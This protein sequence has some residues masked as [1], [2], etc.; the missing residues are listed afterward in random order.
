MGVW[1]SSGGGYAAVR[2]LL[3]FPDFYKVGVSLCGNHDQARYYAHWGDR[4][5]GPYS[6][7]AYFD[8][9]NHRFADRLQ[10]KLLLV[11]GD[12]DDNVHTSAT[13]RLAGAFA[14]ANRDVDLLIYPNSGHGVDQYPMSCAGAGTFL[15]GTFWGR[16]RL[17]T[18]TW[19]R[20]QSS[21]TKDRSQLAAV[22]FYFAV[23]TIEE[24]C[25][26]LVGT[27]EHA[28]K[29]FCCVYSLMGSI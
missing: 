17:Q 16:S 15:S 7:E 24:S 14:R 26:V 2:A 1:G 29:S 12:M 22:F 21:K 28:V 19:K 18:L 4:W 13:L 10:G 25:K 5:I 20:R 27:N 8:Q 3:Q 9:A 23:M 11:H 6:E